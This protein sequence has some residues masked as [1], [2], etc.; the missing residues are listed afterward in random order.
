[1]RIRQVKPEFWSDPKIAELPERTRLFYIG[2][3]GLADDGGWLRWDVT[4]AGGELYRYE[5]RRARERRCQTMFDELVAAGRVKTFPCGHA[6]I[7]NLKKHQHLAGATKQVHTFE[8]EHS[9]CPPPEPAED[10][11]GPEKPADTRGDP[12][13][14]AL[15][16]L[17]NGQ[18]SQG[19]V[20]KGKGAAAASGAASP[21]EFQERMAAAGLA[22]VPA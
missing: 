14:P 8:R 13:S 9:M 2:L 11:G 17:G 5:G 4:E 20:G 1:M 15:V 7:P 18:V 6:W 10:G 12:R 21:S 16:R 19:K 3:W 22:K